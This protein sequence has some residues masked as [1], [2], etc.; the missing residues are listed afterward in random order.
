[1]NSNGDLKGAAVASLPASDGVAHESDRG[2]ADIPQLAG[3]GG[4]ER[5]LTMIDDNDKEPPAAKVVDV[6]QARVHSARPNPLGYPDAVLGDDFRI[7]FGRIFVL[8]NP[9]G[10][11]E[12]VSARDVAHGQLLY[13]F[14]D[15]RSHTSIFHNR[16]SIHGYGASMVGRCIRAQ[17]PESPNPFAACLASKPRKTV[18]PS[19]NRWLE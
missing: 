12:I 13:E 5:L 19:Q 4:E 8:W 17:P 11:V 6:G 1:M 10:D 7:R 18:A 14:G 9:S 3:L 16:S 2:N 15:R